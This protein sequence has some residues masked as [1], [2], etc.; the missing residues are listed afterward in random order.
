MSAISDFLIIREK[1]YETKATIE[2]SKPFGFCTLP[3]GFTMFLNIVEKIE[4]LSVMYFPQNLVRGNHFHKQK[5]EHVYI[6]KGKIKGCFWLPEKENEKREVTLNHGDLFTIK[7]G[8][9]HSLKALEPS[10][11]VEFSTTPLDLKDYYYLQNPFEK[12]D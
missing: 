4:Y 5:E 1:L 2:T 9:A 6:I 7:P 10:I 8:L 3:Y 12:I 11:A